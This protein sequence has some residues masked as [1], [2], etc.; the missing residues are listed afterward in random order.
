MSLLWLQIISPEIL[1]QHA[2][3]GHSDLTGEGVNNSNS[4]VVRQQTL[5]HGQ[6]WHYAVRMIQMKPLIVSIYAWSRTTL[7]SRLFCRSGM[8]AW[9]RTYTPKVTG[10]KLAGMLQEDTFWLLESALTHGV[11]GKVHLQALCIQLSLVHHTA[12]VVYLPCCY[13]R[14]RAHE[15]KISI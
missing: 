10:G 5:K 12:C 8:S 6:K 14:H 2:P 3:R 9:V 4:S 7:G 11:G 13:K 15:A 1:D